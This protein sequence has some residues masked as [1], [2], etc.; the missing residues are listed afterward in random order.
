MVPHA[1]P[2]S[3]LILGLGG[4]TIAQILTQRHGPIPIVGVER[5]PAVAWLAQQEFGLAHLPNVRTVVADAFAFVRRC[6]ERFDAICVDLYI[7]GKM[8]H[9]V[10]GGAFLRDIARLLTPG[11]IA[12]FNLWRS[13]YLADQLRRISEK[14]NIVGRTEVDD[15]VV[16]HC[17]L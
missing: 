5:D 8:S 3:V 15:N 13:P 1:A 14:L 4:G 2:A 10:L 6:D 16:V 12:S 17:S 11:G 7:A 9:G